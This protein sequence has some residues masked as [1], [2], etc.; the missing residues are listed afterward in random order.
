MSQLEAARGWLSPS[1]IDLSNVE[2]QER[3]HL[4]DTAVRDNFRG[5][6]VKLAE[7]RIMAGSIRRMQMGTGQLYRIQSAP[8]EVS[9]VPPG[10]KAVTPHFSLMV[11]YK[12]STLASQGGQTCVLREG[13]LCMIDEAKAFRLEAE[14]VTGFIVA[15]LPRAAVL[16][17]YPHFERLCANVLPSSD[18]GTGLVGDLLLRLSHDADYLGELQRS[19][20]LN[21]I[22]QM[23]GVAGPVAKVPAATHWRVQRALEY[24]E[25]NLSVSGLTAEAVSRDQRISRRRLD[26]L[27][28]DAFGHSIAN[29]LWSRRL[30]QA[31]ADLRDP[32][33]SD[34]SIAQIAFANGFEDAAHFT[35]AF[36]RRFSVTPGQW[37][38]N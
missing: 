38:L 31:A 27:M 6:S 33:Q 37:R 30:E 20:M 23:L 34:R 11:Q 2:Q 12:G 21:G 28:H 13:D 35:R 14:D 17:R 5:L 22:I 29:H 1:L 32:H 4:W 7:P 8:A 18:R 19:A 9:Y 15:R 10:D 25:L 3:K 36:K 16:S 24:I 26:Q